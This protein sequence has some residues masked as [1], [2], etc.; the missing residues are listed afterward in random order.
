MRRSI[1]VAVVLASVTIACVV[2]F[3]WMQTRG[4]WVTVINRG[5]DP[6]TDVVVYVTGSQHS[7]GDLAKGESKT[8]R[9]LPKSESHV[10]LGFLDH[11]G[12]PRRINAGGYFENGYRG[13]IEVELENNTIKRNQQN[14]GPS[15][16]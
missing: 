5:S 1:F 11:L 15:L 8:V 3:A 7:I 13:T 9:V 12:Q 16:F 2:V 6:I 4:V 14:V 10:E